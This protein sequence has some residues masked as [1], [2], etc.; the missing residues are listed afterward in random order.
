MSVAQSLPEVES[1]SLERIRAL[2]IE[3]A[4]SIQQAMLPVEPLRGQAV[5]LVYRFRPVAEV[6]GDFLDYFWLND[7]RLGL[8]IGDVVGKGLPAAMYAA[9]AVGALRGMHKTG[10]T[11]KSVLE[12]LNGRLRVRA[13]PG[14]YCS[15]QY[16]V[17]DPKTQE[18]WQANAGLPKPVIVAPSGCRELGEGGLP[19]G[20]FEGARY[21]QF[22]VKL[23][24]GDAV[25]FATDGLADA[26][27]SNGEDFGME[28]LV[29]TCARYCQEPAEILLNRL[30]AAV[31]DF[32][33]GERQH[34]DMTAAV[35]KLT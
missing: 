31:D 2:E 27:N 25:L 13:I 8:Y 35:L 33:H 19:S 7:S 9:L 18:L 12:V 24:P 26:R 23:A 11:P 20:L 4:R 17:F 30:F 21:D 14:R 22:G 3:E 34:D 16:A 10:S 5:E 1:L 6:G 28:R 15:V 32:C 29:E